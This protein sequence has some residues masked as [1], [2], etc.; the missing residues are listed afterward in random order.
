MFTHKD[1][2]KYGRSNHVQHLI[3][4]YKT[5]K[6]GNLVM[7]G[8]TTDFR[9]YLISTI[10]IGNGLRPSN[11]M[12]IRLCDVRQASRAEGYKGHRVL[13]NNTY[14]T[15]TIYGEKFIVSTKLQ[16]NQGFLKKNW[17]PYGRHFE[18]KKEYLR[19]PIYLFYSIQFFLE[20]FAYV[21]CLKK[22]IWQ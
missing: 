10:C 3:K 11:I 6:S 16:P 8:L 9:D 7:S 14:K 22:S 15:S 20:H 21:L 4:F 12:N 18:I 17:I 5:F 2:I 1:F 19:D 13:I